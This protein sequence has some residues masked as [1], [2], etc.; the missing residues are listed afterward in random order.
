M[1]SQTEIPVLP[2][3][4]LDYVNALVLN[5]LGE[6]LVFEVAKPNSGV[7]WQLLDRYLQP[8]EDPFTAVQQTLQQATGFQACQWAYLGSHAIEASRLF[9]VGF[10]FCAR[11]AYQVAEP[12]LA[13]ATVKWVSLV[14]LRYALLD[15]RISIM[16]HALTVSL[17]LLTVLK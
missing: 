14:D 8:E 10:L 15:G 6:A 4:S 3:H 13:G 11:Q 5:T 12:V 7:Y 1:N 16:S 17:S 2:P 9:G